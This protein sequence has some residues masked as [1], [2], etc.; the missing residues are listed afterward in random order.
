[1]ASIPSVVSMFVYIDTASA[2][3]ILAP[4]GSGSCFSCE[5]SVVEFFMWDF[6]KGKRSFILWSSH[7][8]KIAKK[9]LVLLTT[10]RR[11]MGFL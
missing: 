9:L 11:E 2:V 1:M 8:E 5:I 6:T 3:K 10:G 4:V 7:T